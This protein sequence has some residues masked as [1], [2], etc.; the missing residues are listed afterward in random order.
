[1][2]LSVGKAWDETRSFLAAEGRLVAPVA[3]ATF[4]LPSVLA[5]WAY[6]GSGP[7]SGPGSAGGTGI[8]LMLAVLLAVMVGQMTIALL[9]TGWSGSIGEAMGK[10]VRRLPSLIGAM[11]V[12]F[13]P[14]AMVAIIL[15][16][17]ALA[18]AGLTDPETLTPEVLAKV[19]NLWWMLLLLAV[20]FIIVAVRLFPIS[21]IAATETGGPIALLRRSLAL[22]KGQFGRLLVLML[23]LMLAA[24]VLDAAVTAVVGSIAS[25][26]LGEARPFNLSALM[27]ALAGGLV[28][29]MVSSVSAAM[30][31]RVYAQLAVQPSVP[32]T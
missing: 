15:L 21:A 16:G 25:L 8:L 2:K 14:I 31:G 19:P 9:A 26:A 20:A 22:T 24:V 28:G 32:K 6:P 23:L 29:A 3:L 10:A 12:V 5:A 27:V 1:L 30:V 17:S 7:G 18:A 4:A 13:L 11:L